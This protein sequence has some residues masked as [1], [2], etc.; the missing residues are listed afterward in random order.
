MG[1]IM[2]LLVVL[3][4][5]FEYDACADFVNECL[6]LAPALFESAFEHGA[7]GYDTGE[8]LVVEVERYVG[9]LLCEAGCKLPHSLLVFRGLS[10]GLCGQPQHHGFY[11]FFLKIV[12]QEVCEFVGGHGA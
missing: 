5:V 3:H 2:C 4:V 7:M 1:S 8:A 9:K 6:V 10:A 12:F 11:V